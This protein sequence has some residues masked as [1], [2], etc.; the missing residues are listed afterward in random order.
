MSRFKIKEL[1]EAKGY[2]IN[3]FAEYIGMPQGNLSNIANGRANP[4]DKTLQTIAD[5][6]GVEVPDIYNRKESVFICPNCNAVYE[7]KKK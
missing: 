3:S 4:T 5:N 6:L 7:L 1:I 2:S